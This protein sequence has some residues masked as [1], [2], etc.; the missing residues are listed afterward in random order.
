MTKAYKSHKISVNMTS[1]C[2]LFLVHHDKASNSSQLTC[3][4]SRILGNTLPSLEYLG[5]IVHLVHHSQRPDFKEKMPN[6]NAINAFSMTYD[7]PLFGT[8]R[9]AVI[10]QEVPTNPYKRFPRF[11][12]VGSK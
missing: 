12:F 3:F 5:G 4:H 10:P 7:S 2:R 1:F 11:F 8:N 6:A 9:V